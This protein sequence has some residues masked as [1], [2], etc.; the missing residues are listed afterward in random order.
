MFRG[1]ERSFF[2]VFWDVKGL[3]GLTGRHTAGTNDGLHVPR[4]SSDRNGLEL[5]DAD[6]GKWLKE[7]DVMPSEMSTLLER[8]VDARE[9]G[10]PLEA[11]ANPLA[12]S[13]IVIAMALCDPTIFD[14]DQLF[15]LIAVLIAQ[16]HPLFV[17]WTFN[18]WVID[19]MLSIR[20]APY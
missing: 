14:F 13:H 15:E 1:E 12:R 16:M 18:S 2:V 10:L 11:H 9:S 7:R 8:L 6:V 3:G 19:G 17:L 5:V 4:V 20:L